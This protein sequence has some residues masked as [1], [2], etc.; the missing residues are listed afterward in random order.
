MDDVN[1]LVYCPSA[2]DDDEC[3]EGCWKNGIQSR[4]AEKER[5]KV[6]GKSL[7]NANN[8]NWLHFIFK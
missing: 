8:H 1:M 5:E 6:E 7:K 2:N 4:R 3:I